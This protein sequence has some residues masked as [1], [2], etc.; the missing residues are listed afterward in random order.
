MKDWCLECA[1]FNK[2]MG[3]GGIRGGFQGYVVNLRYCGG[4]AFLH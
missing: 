1:A 3:E 2:Q 4:L